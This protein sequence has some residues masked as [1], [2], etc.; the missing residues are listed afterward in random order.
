VLYAEK[1]SEVRHRRFSARAVLV[2]SWDGPSLL[3]R[4][5]SLHFL[6]RPNHHNKPTL[7]PSPVH[8]AAFARAIMLFHSMGREH[9]LRL[10]F[11]NL[12]Y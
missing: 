8:V 4:I 2:T 3:C 12:F 11:F 7:I 6:I 10:M 1:A 5:S 9:A